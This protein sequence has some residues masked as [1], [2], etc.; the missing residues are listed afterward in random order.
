MFFELSNWALFFF[1]I[2]LKKKDYETSKDPKSVPM[3]IMVA[4]PSVLILSVA[5]GFVCW[6][7]E[8]EKQRR[9]AALAALDTGWSHAFVER[10]QQQQE[11]QQRAIESSGGVE[12]GRHQQQHGTCHSRQTLTSGTGSPHLLNE[13]TDAVDLIIGKK[14]TGR[15][16]HHHG[17]VQPNYYFDRHGHHQ[18]DQ[19]QQRNTSS[20]L[21]I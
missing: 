7:R 2:Y 9:Q 1:I 20:S 6:M 15:L 17:D 5:A 18:L 4:L 14:R 11:Q 10:Q 13:E 8:R 16:A 12:T 21:I 19:Q 3:S